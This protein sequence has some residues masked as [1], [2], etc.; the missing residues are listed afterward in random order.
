MSDEQKT[1][2]TND[3]FFAQAVTIDQIVGN[4]EQASYLVVVTGCFGLADELADFHMAIPVKA[5]S[6]FVGILGRV[7][8]ES[9]PVPNLTVVSSEPRN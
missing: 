8:A 1:L 7:A 2:L 9:T 6:N 3:I 5:W 4:D